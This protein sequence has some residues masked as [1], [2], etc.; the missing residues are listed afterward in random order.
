MMEFGRYPTPQE[1][2]AL[3]RRAHRMRSQA[4][5]ATLAHAAR[6]SRRALVVLRRR[7]AV[8]TLRLGRTLGDDLRYI[9]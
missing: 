5:A 9:S 4:I 8:A 6:R 2:E 3:M 1:I 7:L